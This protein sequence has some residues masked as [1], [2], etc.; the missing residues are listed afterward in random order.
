MPDW[1][2]KLLFWGSI[3]IAVVVVIGVGWWAWASWKGNSSWSFPWSSTSTTSIP[4]KKALREAGESERKLA[5]QYAEERKK[6]E[7]NASKA[8]KEVEALRPQ[9][10]DSAG[11]FLPSKFA[12]YEAAR[13]RLNEAQFELKRLDEL[14]EGG[15]K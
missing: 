4:L 7:E 5:R 1:L 10:T 11:K 13:D 15:D 14:L 2:K 6:L 8:S 12:E 9:L 3:I